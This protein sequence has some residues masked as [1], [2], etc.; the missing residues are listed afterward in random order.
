MADRVIITMQDILES[1]SLISTTS[2]SPSWTILSSADCHDDEVGHTS[3]NSIIDSDV[4]L[5]GEL[6]DSNP[7]Q[8]SS[9][10]E[11]TS[12]NDF[13]R[14]MSDIEDFEVSQP[15]AYILAT[16]DGQKKLSLSQIVTKACHTNLETVLQSQ[17]NIEQTSEEKIQFLLSLETRCHQMAAKYQSQCDV[18]RSQ[19]LEAEL[20]SFHS[21]RPTGLRELRKRKVKTEHMA[22]S[23]N[24]VALGIINMRKQIQR[25]VFHIKSNSFYI[26]SRY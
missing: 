16:E 10:T 2:S 26:E 12:T 7:S 20:N 19:V 4:I 11:G 3:G 21:I 25:E 1:S 23:C 17:W 9:S 5:T 14:A 15:D 18:F 6:E 8:N 13:S 22:H 24:S